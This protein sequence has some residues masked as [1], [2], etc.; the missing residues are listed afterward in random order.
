MTEDGADTAMRLAVINSRVWANGISSLAMPD[1]CKSQ[2]QCG[3]IPVPRDPCCD[4]QSN[5]SLSS[6]IRC[7]M[8]DR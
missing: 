3:I 6:Y 8:L 1:P 7:L 5:V 4:R 2:E